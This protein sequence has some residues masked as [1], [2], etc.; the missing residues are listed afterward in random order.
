MMPRPQARL[1]C[2]AA[3][4]ERP[5]GDADAVDGPRRPARDCARGGSCAPRTC[6]LHGEVIGFH[7]ST[8]T[9]GHRGSG[10]GA[11]A[12]K[13][14]LV[15]FGQSFVVRSEEHTSELQSLAY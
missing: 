6:R 4:A 12:S 5:L 11:I 2:P 7:P 9:S 10:P 15:F 13:S 14:E 3:N 1:K 8:L